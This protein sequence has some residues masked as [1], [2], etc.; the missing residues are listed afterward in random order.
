M[1]VAQWRICVALCFGNRRRVPSS[2][3][4]RTS[5]PLL[6]QKALYLILLQESDREG[7]FSD[8]FFY[9]TEYELYTGDSLLVAFE[10][11]FIAPPSV[12]EVHT[13]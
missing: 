1:K 6:L 4:N 2:V 13:K 7:G 3:E 12:L 10:S 8:D 5:V 9:T 11:G